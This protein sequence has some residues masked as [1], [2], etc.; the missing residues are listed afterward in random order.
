MSDTD[1]ASDANGSNEGVDEKKNRRGQPLDQ[2][3]RQKLLLAM[4]EDRLGA[5]VERTKLH[6]RT[7]YAAAS[8]KAVDR[9]TATL[10]KIAL[11]VAA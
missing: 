7:I 8:G 9:S 11:D 6:E 10:I 5:I 4:G 2:E 3:L 1:R